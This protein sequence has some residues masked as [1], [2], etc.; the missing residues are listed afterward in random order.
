MYATRGDEIVDNLVN[1]TFHYSIFVEIVNSETKYS[2]SSY[3][4]DI[5]VKRN[6]VILK[7]K[8]GDVGVS[9]VAQERPL[10]KGRGKRC[11]R[12][13]SPYTVGA[14]SISARETLPPYNIG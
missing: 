5:I 2:Q 9:A 3:K 11:A 13:P 7:E 4:Q 12:T 10:P 1:S 8:I 14:D 6:F